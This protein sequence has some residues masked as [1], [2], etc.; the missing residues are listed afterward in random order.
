MVV[1]SFLCPLVSL[2]FITTLLVKITNKKFGDCFPLTIMILPLILVLIHYT[3]RNLIFG[4]YIIYALVLYSIVNFILNIKNKEFIKNVFTVGTYLFVSIYVF[5]FAI[6]RNNYYFAWDEFAHWGPM[7]NNLVS[8][9]RMYV[10]VSHASY[11]PLVQLFEYTLVRLGLI[12]EEYNM[13]FAVLLFDFSIFCVPFSEKLNTDNKNS[14][15]NVLKALLLFLI[16]FVLASGIDSYRSLS[17]IYLD[18]TLSMF[19]AYIMHLIIYEEDKRIIALSTFA[20]TLV[21]DVSVLFVII[22]MIYVFSNALITTI[23]SSEKKYALRK[24]SNQ[25]VYI[26]VPAV[27]SYLFWHIYKTLAKLLNDQFAVSKFSIAKFFEIF[28]GKI[29]GERLIAFTEYF[30]AI[31]TRNLARTPIPFTY[32]NSFLLIIIMLV[33]FGIAS[34][35]EFDKIFKF[36]MFSILAYFVYMLFMLNMYVNIFVGDESVNLA[37]YTRYM[38]SFVLG[39]VLVLLVFLYKNVNLKREIIVAFSIISFLLGLSFI[40]GIGSTRDNIF[41]DKMKYERN[42][43][44][45]LSKHANEN[46][47]SIVVI[48]KY[49]ASDLVKNYYNTN[50]VTIDLYDISEISNS[51]KVKAFYD[52]LENYKYI[53]IIDE[54]EFAFNQFL[55]SVNQYL[56]ENSITDKYKLNTI[57]AN[58]IMIIN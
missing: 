24:F 32:F 6:T 42:I 56:K 10:N 46:E 14:F 37:S 53:C 21:K 15:Y 2:F 25:I 29:S 3:I 35:S 7:I 36:I 54:S 17:T 26:L 22:I 55:S 11:P 5:L 18:V 47:K 45:Q 13:K 16:T 1:I 52:S 51:D 23:K 49:V 30:K 31:F 19:F 34:K 43:Y 50:G 58:K 20:F 39:M 9:N 28:I 4:V 12:F 48:G 33:I 44:K 38:S 57:E 8:N 27:I 41:I 40:K